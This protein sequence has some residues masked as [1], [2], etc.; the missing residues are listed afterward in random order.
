LRLENL[1]GPTEAA[2]YAGGYSLGDWDGKS[3][4]PIGKPLAN[5]RLYVLSKYNEVQPIGVAG[6]LCISGAG[7]ARGYLNNPGLTAEKFCLRRPGGR[8]LKKLPPW[9]PRKNFSL[10]ESNDQCPITNDRLYRTG[11]LA[12]WLADGNLEYLGRMDYQVKI[13]GFRVE[14]GEIENQLLKHPGVTGAVVADRTDETGNRYLCAYIVTKTPGLTGFK[15]FL[16]QTIP[17]YMIPSSFVI[18]EEIPV[19]SSG[20]VDRW[21]LPSPAIGIGEDYTAP[22]DPVE[23]TLARLWS[24]LLAIDKGAVGIDDNFFDLGGHSLR[25]TILAAKIYREFQVR[26][27]LGQ[28]FQ[29][30]T[31]RGI[32]GFIKKTARSRFIAVTPVEKKEYYPL[33]SAQKQFY[34]MQQLDRSTTTYNLPSVLTLEGAVEKEI[35]EDI[36]MGLIRR[37]ET[38]RTSFAIVDGKPVQRVHDNV[39]FKIA[40]D[41]L[42]T[43]AT[44]DT[45]AGGTNRQLPAISTFIRSFD[46][47]RA[48]LLRVGLI[49]LEENRHIFM[50][51]MHHILSD[52]LSQGILVNE[53]AALYSGVN[54]PGLRLQYRDYAH[55]QNRQAL[56][57]E[58][59]KQE[60]YWTAEFK[61]D[62][63]VLKI[64]ADFPRPPVKSFAGS[65]MNFELDGDAARKL[66]NLAGT[67]NATLFMLYLSVVYVLLSKLSGREDII[68]GTVAAG[69]RHPDLENIIGAF[70]NTLPLRNYPGEDKTFRQFLREVRKRTLEAFDNQDYRF[71]DLVQKVMVARDTSRN[72]LFDILYSFTV[73]DEDG[74]ADV[75]TS[76]KPDQSNRDL[77]VGP[78]G[79]EEAGSARFD[80]TIAGRGAGDRCGFFFEYSTRLFKKET[81]GRYISYFKEIAAAAA[82]DADIVLKDI[83]IST[84][85]RA[86]GADVYDDQS[87]FEF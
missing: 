52:F 74:S 29:T 65:M 41:D 28:I 42:A 24:Q 61:G 32:S 40:Y 63:P 2:V 83:V 44:G 9:T 10:E 87:E 69:R 62:I 43:G 8:F 3:A 70:I 77:R 37:H 34:V 18:L 26:I 60:E 67:E 36:V 13:R 33:S 64:P 79:G 15:E 1:Y 27:T 80:I 11:D 48:P 71:E 73:G 81:M 31:I 7:L 25:A 23:E 30:P 19:T 75:E 51:D 38:L 46:L 47:S 72:P 54:L 17:D 55:W 53:V 45:G 35:L 21:A 68:V 85:L 84:D 4:V 50:F 6:E 57:G 56:S 12:R 22:R 20:K 59:K 49:R 86:A 58:I 78:Y 39:E 82:N 66:A 5:V 16:S 14:L 76:G